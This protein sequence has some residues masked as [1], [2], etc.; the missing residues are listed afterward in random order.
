M[1]SFNPNDFLRKVHK[2]TLGEFLAAHGMLTKVDWAHMPSRDLGPVQEAWS[3]LPEAD[4]ERMEL[5]FR[6]VWILGRTND[7][8][9]CA[10]DLSFDPVTGKG[11]ADEVS[12]VPGLLGKALWIHQHHQDVFEDACELRAFD[13]WG[14]RTRWKRCDLPPGVAPDL[15]PAA[16]ETLRA[17]VST[18]YE[19]TQGCGKRCTLH[20]VQRGDTHFWFLYPEDHSEEHLDYQDDEPEPIILHPAFQV[21]FAYEPVRGSLEICARTVGDGRETLEAAFAASILHGRMPDQVNPPPVYTLQCLLDRHHVFA[22]I[23]GIHRV[24][25]R[26]LRCLILG[27]GTKSRN[28]MNTF[29]AGTSDDPIDIYRTM[30]RIIG[31]HRQREGLLHVVSATIQV[32]LE[33]T[34]RRGARKRVDF[35][36]T[37]PDG[38]NLEDDPEH[39]MIRDAL[40]TW[41]LEAPHV[42]VAAPAA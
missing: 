2:P 34:N 35:T 4:R 22:P 20:T 3:L 30:D 31:P 11:F 10:I 36:I 25:I 27:A 32:W 37:I 33:E 17:Q 26:S 24:R 1:Q 6:K 42:P 40:V 13:T 19:Q 23:K 14:R 39:R 28:P 15:G 12:H 18:F 9:R 38:C 21:I 8:I 29:N 5:I 41:D 16:Q 7:G